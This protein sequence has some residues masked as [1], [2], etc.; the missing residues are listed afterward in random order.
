MLAENNNVLNAGQIS[1]S[2]MRSVC[3]GMYYRASR[4]DYVFSMVGKHTQPL[5]DYIIVSRRAVNQ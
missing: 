5:E 2:V 4:G 3:I 1:V